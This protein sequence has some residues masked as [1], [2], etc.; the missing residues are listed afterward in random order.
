MTSRYGKSLLLLP[1]G[2]F[3]VIVIADVVVLDEPWRLDRSVGQ[4]VS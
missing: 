2:S 4:S 3:P 1:I